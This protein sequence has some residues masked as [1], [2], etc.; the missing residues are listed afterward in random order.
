MREICTSGSV[1]GEDRK[2]LTYPA[3][4]AARYLGRESLNSKL[5]ANV[6]FGAHSG[7]KPDIARGRKGAA[8]KSG[9]Y[10]EVEPAL[11]SWDTA[12]TNCAGANGF[13]SR[14]LLGTPSDA[15]SS[16]AAPVM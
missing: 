8:N 7:I 3:G 14:M 2:A 13:F 11:S 1:G 12:V 5:S 16:A 10:P 4:V 15:Q 9:G 6:R